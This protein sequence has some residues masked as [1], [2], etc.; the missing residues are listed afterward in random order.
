M[1]KHTLNLL[2]LLA[3]LGYSQAVPASDKNLR[4][5][6]SVKTGEVF[7]IVG[8]AG[9]L[10]L[11]TEKGLFKWSRPPDGVPEQIPTITAAV[12]TLLQDGNTNTL[13][14]GSDQGLFRWDSPERGGGPQF[15]PGS[16]KSISKLHKFG[17]KLLISADKGLYVWQNSSPN[18]VKHVGVAGAFVNAFCPDGDNK[19]WIGAERGLLRW[20]SENEAPIP[21]PA[22]GAIEV[23]SLYKENATSTLVIGTANSL[24][25]WVNTPSGRPETVLSEVKVYSLYKDGSMLLIS[26][27][28]E[29]LFRL[30]DIQ[31]GKPTLI[32]KEI[33]TSSRYFR[34]GPILWMGAGLAGERGLY[35]W[36]TETEAEPRRIK[37]IITGAV[38]DFFKSSRT[39][40]I[41]AE[42]G[43]YRLEGL[44]TGWDAKIKVTSKVPNIL[45]NDNYLPIQWQIGNYGWRTTPD[46]VRTRVVVKGEE[47][48]QVLLDGV[49]CIGQQK[50]TLPPLPKG[51]YLVKIQATDLHGQESVS[52]ELNFQVYS[53]FSDVITS[54]VKWMI[55]PVYPVVNVFI[56]IILLLFSRWFQWP[57]DILNHKSVRAFGIYY[58]FVL[59]HSS[60]VRVWVFNR[61]Y[62]ELKKEFN[63]ERPYVLQEIRT[64]DG[65][66]I[67][68]ADLLEHF[69]NTPHILVQGEPG[70]G[71]TE[72]LKNILKNYCSHPT[73]KK[74]YQRYRFIP[75]MIPLR[76]FGNP[77]DP[78]DATTMP[79]LAQAAF[80]GMGMWFKDTD[81]LEGLIDRKD[82]LII[83]DGLNEV[84]LDKQIIRFAATTREVKL[85]MTSQTALP[86]SKE[87]QTYRLSALTPDFAKA[88][89]G[90]FIEPADAVRVVEEMPEGFWDDIKSGYDVRL[91]QNLIDAG[92]PL[93]SNR[94][95]LYA[96]AL[97]YASTKFSG[98]YPLYV[99]YKRAWD[100]WKEKKRRFEPDEKLP[101]TLINPLLEAKV[102]VA[103]GPQYEFR[104]DLMR[105][106]LAAYWLAREAP[107]ID[108]TKER[109][110]E[111]E[112]W[113]L[114]SSE[115]KLVFPFL[116]EM[117][118][119]QE[120]LEQVAQFASD[121]V[122]RRTFLLAECQKTAK[123][124]GWS[125]KVHLNLPSE[126]L[127][128][129]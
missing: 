26:I 109:L 83:L 61:Y 63:E 20:D 80:R 15:I 44:G 56:F 126:D 8:D 74:A 12:F 68:P 6:L 16:P 121:E 9:T 86:E 75:V 115:Q 97:D 84:N 38:H 14:I 113:D 48:Q 43:I 88:L 36:N 110:S 82:F 85:L 114:S 96:A 118:N 91:I 66:A 65:G 34:S 23:T 32:S 2:L 112:V 21:V 25:R 37:T 18:S 60:T 1:S 30:D 51:K 17:T 40:W 7:T 5:D 27:E 73:L 71:K 94:L 103:R 72:L 22:I 98:E 31:A 70:T 116:A 101:D 52:D 67:Q 119:T 90:A 102:L 47:G 99:L 49:E 55:L 79:N 11:A 45:Y 77:A 87:V 24:L 81:F 104:H 64:P 106:Y 122:A 29:G 46:E 127:L 59:Y 35:R 53:S 28:R 129:A 19:V 120:D 107:S 57:L 42:T 111:E 13:W 3:L 76:E 10:W 41:G 4:V 108:V 89:L 117:I 33:G 50:F 128:K 39:L 95:E 93:P 123:T 58:G 78:G 69:T 92:R 54:W 125:L 124:K 100:M 105:G 62:N